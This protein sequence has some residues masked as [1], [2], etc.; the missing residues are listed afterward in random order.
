MASRAR[1][2]PR[3]PSFSL[4]RHFSFSR[5]SFSPDTPSLRPANERKSESK[6]PPLAGPG[7]NQSSFLFDVSTMMLILMKQIAVSVEEIMDEEPSSSL[8]PFEDLPDKKLDEYALCTSM[9]ALFQL[10][11]CCSR[12][13]FVRRCGISRSQLRELAKLARDK[14]FDFSAL[15]GFEKRQQAA[16]SRSGVY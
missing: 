12:S 14:D 5:D 8:F 11:S 3:M 7:T 16:E 10:I 15:V 13:S 9:I 4:C 2:S 6:D 1:F